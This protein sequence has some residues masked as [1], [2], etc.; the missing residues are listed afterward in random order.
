MMM[1]IIP[2]K[3]SLTSCAGTAAAAGWAAGIVKRLWVGARV[4]GTAPGTCTYHH[5]VKCPVN[6]MY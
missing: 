2:T 6:A 5:S 4:M 1:M 3:K